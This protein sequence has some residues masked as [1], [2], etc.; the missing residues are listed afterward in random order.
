M[1]AKVATGW[2]SRGCLALLL[3]TC[4][5]THAADGQYPSRPVRL[6]MPYPAGSS[7][8]DILGRALA[9]PDV[10]E[11][12]RVADYAATGLDPKAS[13]AWLASTRGK[14]AKIIADANLRVD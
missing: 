7:S 14:L 4:A 6:I 12:N 5:P 2:R 11:K 8:N 10:A 9:Q 1:I 13:A 3:A